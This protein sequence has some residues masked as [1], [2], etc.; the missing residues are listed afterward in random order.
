MCFVIDPIDGTEELLTGRSG[1][2][3]S[4]ALFHG[5]QPH[6]AVLDFP[7]RGHR[8]SCGAGLGAWVVDSTI[9]LRQSRALADARIVVSATQ[10]RLPELFS[11]WGGL[12]VAE[13]VPILAFRRG[14]LS[15]SEQL[16]QREGAMRPRRQHEV[17][18][19]SGLHDGV[20]ADVG[21]VAL[22]LVSP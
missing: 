21:I 13:T 4:I 1:F 6:A 7:A 11:V 9:R 8:F 17:L 22:Q 16:D 14:P 5:R 3:I 15:V 19:V 10:R 18:P 20:E 2:A 12:R